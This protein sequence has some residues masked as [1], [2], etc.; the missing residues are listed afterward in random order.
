M[1]DIDTSTM[2]EATRALLWVI[3]V[4]VAGGGGFFFGRAKKVKLEPNV[5][6]VDT[7]LCKC[8]RDNNESEHKNAFFRIA[9]LEQRVSHIEGEMGHINRALERIENKLDDIRN[10]R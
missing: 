9:A 8:H 10:V 5:I 1:S 7:S 6:E 2:S 3:G 4:L